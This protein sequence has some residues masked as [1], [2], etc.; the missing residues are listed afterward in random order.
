MKLTLA[1]A[2]LVAAALAL[3]YLDRELALA[4]ALGALLLV[5]LAAA[6]GAGAAHRAASHLDRCID[7][8]AIGCVPLVLVWARP[9]LLAASPGA[10][11]LLVA[12]VAAPAAAAFIK[13]GLPLVHR[14]PG[15][16]LARPALLAAALAFLL[17][18]ATWTVTAAAAVALCAAGEQ[19]AL[20]ALL[21]HPLPE[22]TTLAAAARA[23]RDRPPDLV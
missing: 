19:L 13:Y 22:P 5:D 23:R 17:L 10:T 21:E 8:A 12:A 9:R 1:R 6:R 11:W 20:T 3:G 14:A 2:A 18:G 4:V 15:E 16:R 7:A